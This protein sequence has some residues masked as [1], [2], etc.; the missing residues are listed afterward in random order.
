[1]DLLKLLKDKAD[2]F[3]SL[4]E[5]QGI[6]SIVSHIEVA[7][8]HYTSGKQGDDYL[9]NDVIYRSNQAF[10]GAL[11]EAYR[12]ITGKIEDKITPYKIE[13]YFEDNGVLK[14]RVLQLFTNYRKEWRNKSTHDYK[15]YFSEQEAFLAIVNISAFVNIL[16]DQ[17]LE[18]TAYDKEREDLKSKSYKVSNNFSNQNLLEKTIELLKLFSDEISQKYSGATI[19]WITEVQLIGALTAFINNYAQEIKVFPDYTINVES[20]KKRYQIDFLLELDNSKL[21]IEVK[22]PI[23]RLGDMIAS[24]TEQLSQYLAISE[25]QTGILYIPPLAHSKDMEI[26]KIEKNIAGKECTIIQILPSNQVAD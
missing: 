11:K 9:F 23:R 16:F 2:Y 3:I 14:E 12:I 20:N 18:K 21:I 25:A 13:Q 7:E 10:E 24:G 22:N 5:D 15:L 1:M 6:S 17:M 26:V 4:D 19:P 8:R